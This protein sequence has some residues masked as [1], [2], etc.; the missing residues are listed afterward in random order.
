MSKRSYA[1]LLKRAGL[2]YRRFHILRHTCATLLLEDGVP[3]QK[4]SAL[5]GHASISITADLYG[6]LATSDYQRD[7]RASAE[8]LFG[9][10]DA[11]ENATRNRGRSSVDAG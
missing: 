1:P 8:R 2:P 10:P 11:A 7:T 9:S 3:L 5:L 6:H 4:V